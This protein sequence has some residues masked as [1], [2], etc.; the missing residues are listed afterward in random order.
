MHLID[1]NVEEIFYCDDL[2]PTVANTT[3]PIKDKGK[4]TQA[5]VAATDGQYC[6]PNGYL[7]KGSLQ[8]T[9]TICHQEKF[10]PHQITTSHERSIGFYYK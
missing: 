3:D 4:Q 5:S 10:H 9:L 6:L 7:L 8:T 2:F 1:E